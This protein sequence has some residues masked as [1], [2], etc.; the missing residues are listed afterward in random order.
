MVALSEG[1]LRRYKILSKLIKFSPEFLPDYLGK[2]I[3]S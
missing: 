1:Y 3:C 2:E